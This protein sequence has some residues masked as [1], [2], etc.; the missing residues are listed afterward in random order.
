MND[1][2]GVSPVTPDH[3]NPE[4]AW[5][6]LAALAR[7]TRAGG[8]ELVERLAL[9][10]AFARKADRWVDASL[11]PRVERLRDTQGYARE[12]D[13]HAGS[14]TP[15]PAAVARW[16]HPARAPRGRSPR[17]I[18]AA[19]DGTPLE[20]AAIA[21]L[22]RARG[23]DLAAVIEA[24]DELRRGAVGDGASYVVNR[25]INYTNICTFRCHFCA[26]SKGRTRRH[27]GDPGYLR[28][29]DEIA[30][31]TREAWERGATEVCLQGGIHPSL[32]GRQYL[33]I[34]DVVKLAA[35]QIHV[36]AFSPLEIS[37]GADTLGLSRVSSGVSPTAGTPS[38]PGTAA[39]ILD[40][41]VRAVICPDKLMTDEWLEV[42]ATAHDVGLRS[43]ATIMF[44][45][46]DGYEHWA[47]HPEA[48][49]WV[50]GPDR[51]LHRV[52]PA[53]LRPHGSAALAQGRRAL[54]PRF[55]RGAPHACGRTPRAAPGD[56]P[57]SRCHG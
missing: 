5:P 3:V 40:D 39:E 11:R 7:E 55:P 31:R 16:W 30:G 33:D 1:W 51:R 25:N 38:L 54:R 15:P 13:W 52:R 45:H 49:P 42:M 10:P 26:F 6:D 35:P 57:M 28:S 19:K 24:A 14:L 9:V 37:H 50:A 36:H 47:R 8:R 18:S 22:F 56:C 2:G 43:T 4:A 32:H 48:D 29:L 23:D 41:D 34:I 44:G 21:G 17:T 46:V 12:D 20:E 27:C 53:A